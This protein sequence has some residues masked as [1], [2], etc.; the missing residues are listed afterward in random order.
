M[1]DTAEALLHSRVSGTS[2]APAPASRL[3]GAVRMLSN[4]VTEIFER[5]LQREFAGHRLSASQWKLLII[6]ATT[7]VSNVSEVA[8]YQGVSTAAASKAVQR[9]SRMRLVTRTVDPRDRRHVRLALS[10]EGAKLTDAYLR[11]LDRSLAELSSPAG[12]ESL[13]AAS[14]MLDQLTIAVLRA[15][16]DPSAI[17]IQCEFNGRTG[18]LIREA[19]QRNCHLGSP[20][21]ELGP[22]PSRATPVAPEAPP[23]MG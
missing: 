1:T 14:Q 12:Q 9:L 3:L 10:E 2:A 17:C 7:A 18:C 4:A 6:L 15:A 11:N 20:H 19:L 21:E 5:Q 22:G 16:A 8:A 23:V 13:A